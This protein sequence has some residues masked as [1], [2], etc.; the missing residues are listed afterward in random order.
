[1]LISWIGR[2]IVRSNVTAVRTEV[3]CVYWSI[4]ATRKTAVTGGDAGKDR[5][6][7][8][9]DE[10]GFGDTACAP[11]NLSLYG[12]PPWM[13]TTCMEPAWNPLPATQQEMKCVNRTGSFGPAKTFV[14]ALATGLGSGYLP[15][16]GTCGTAVIF[17]LHRFF[18]PTAFVPGSLLSGLVFVLLVIAVAVGAAEFA[19][20]HYKAKD[21]GRITIDEVA[22][23]LVAVY[24]LPAGWT[25][26]IA[27][28]LLFRVMDIVKPPPARG[29]QA[30]HGGIGIVIDDVIAALYA[31][32]ILN[33]VF[34]WV[35]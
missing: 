29:L 18:F 24:G 5:L 4:I 10:F 20:R 11:V 3:S 35:L 16:S 12:L 19:E 13:K 2:R 8:S 14:L 28:F 15:I 9:M 6:R 25:P 7:R 32:G 30:L 34:H 26:A 1:M 17:L 22:G 33:V 31:C 23:Y 21:D 27:A